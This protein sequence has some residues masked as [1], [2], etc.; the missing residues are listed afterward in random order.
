[1]HHQ[2]GVHVSRI[3]LLFVFRRNSRTEA[4]VRPRTRHLNSDEA[5][6]RSQTKRPSTENISQLPASSQSAEYCT[7]I[8]HM[9]QRGRTCPLHKS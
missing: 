5:V 6:V 2:L 7:I 1:M 9:A 8:E 3:E 4:V